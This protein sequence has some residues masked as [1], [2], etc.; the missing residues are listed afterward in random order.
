[1]L[2]FM[3]AVSSTAGAARIVADPKP[4]PCLP[5]RGS[6]SQMETAAVGTVR[7][8][9]SR[10][11]QVVTLIAVV[12][13]PLGLVS[14]I[15]LL[16]G[17]GFHWVDLAP[18][19][20]PLRRVRLRDDDRLPPLLHAQGLRGARA[21]EGAA[22]DPRLHDDAGPGHPVGHGSP[23]APRALRQA[24]RPALAARRSR[25]GRL[26]SAARLR[27]RARRLDVLEPRHGA[28]PRVRARPLRGQARPHDRPHV[29]A[30]GGA[31]ARDPVRDRATASAAPGRP[32]SRVSSGAA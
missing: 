22:R 32:A 31:D 6:L 9:T 21:G 29:S 17:V 4:T 25:R 1:M 16:W 14:A 15:G 23:Q 13:P 28:G 10:I 12:V 27:A 11:S 18:L 2:L 20:R 19:P 5:R 24:R 3:Q 8:R 26:G 30:L 7:S